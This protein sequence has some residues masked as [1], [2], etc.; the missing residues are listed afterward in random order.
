MPLP[1]RWRGGSLG[2]PATPWRRR[3]RSA[4]PHGV[5]SPRLR[6]AGPVGERAMRWADEARAVILRVTTRV[7]LSSMAAASAG[8]RVLVP[9]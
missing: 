4:A 3:G 8:L 7:P 9:Q 1:L 2:A 5:R 6:P